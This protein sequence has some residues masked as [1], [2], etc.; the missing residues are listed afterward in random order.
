LSALQLRHTHTL[1]SQRQW[2]SEQQRAGESERLRP[3][4]Y[5]IPY[6]G[7]C[8]DSKVV[9][10][11]GHGALCREFWDTAI[12]SSS[13]NNAEDVNREE[14]QIATY[15]LYSALLL[16]RALIKGSAL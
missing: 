7:W 2:L 9:H 6:L 11:V 12:V 13:V 1:R 4:L 10:Y 5:T 8:T 3:K 16:T 15:F 14:C